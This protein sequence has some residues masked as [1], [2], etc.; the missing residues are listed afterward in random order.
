M[1][2]KI[3]NHLYDN[4]IVKSLSCLPNRESLKNQSCHDDTA[5]GL[6]CY[7]SCTLYLFFASFHLAV[8]LILVYFFMTVLP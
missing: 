5:L 6:V 8:D 3:L 2:E 7:E 1:C 4:V